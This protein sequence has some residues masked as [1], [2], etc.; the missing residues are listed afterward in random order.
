MPQSNLGD[1]LVF[2]LGRPPMG[3]FLGF[4]EANSNDAQHL[5][6][7]KLAQEWR[8]ANDHLKTIETSE[9]GLADYPTIASIPTELE[10]LKQRVLNDPMFQRSFAMIPTDIGYVELD[11]LVVFQKYIN[12]SY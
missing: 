1:D 3:E 10:P 9:S 8:D 12:L 2:L 7:S 4:A 6:F 11:K 5:D